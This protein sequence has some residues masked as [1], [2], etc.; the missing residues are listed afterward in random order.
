MTNYIA[1][2]DRMN[3]ELETLWKEEVTDYLQVLQ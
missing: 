1:S 3:S 2:N